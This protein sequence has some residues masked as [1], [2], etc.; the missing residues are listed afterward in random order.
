MSLTVTTGL[1]KATAAFFEGLI[2][3]VINRSTET[4]RQ[5]A[6]AAHWNTTTNHKPLRSL[7]QTQ[8]ARDWYD[9]CTSS[10]LFSI[11]TLARK[12]ED[13][14]LNTTRW[15]TIHFSKDIIER[16]QETAHEAGIKAS[17]FNLLASWIHL[18]RDLSTSLGYRVTC[19]SERRR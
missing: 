19:S 4:V 6:L 17:K 18:V 9:V 5:Y 11:K 13:A 16:W 14:R 12:W 2:G 3:N 1:Y 7:L 10:K 8:Q 15:Q